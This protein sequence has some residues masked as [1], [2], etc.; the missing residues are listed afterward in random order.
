MKRPSRYMFRLPIYSARDLIKILH[1]GGYDVV[2]QKGSHII[3]RD[4]AGRILSVPNHDEIARGTLRSI[5]KQSGMP[6][7]FFL[8]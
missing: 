2:R 8:G 5:I 3:L 6:R 4:K 7:D 1:E